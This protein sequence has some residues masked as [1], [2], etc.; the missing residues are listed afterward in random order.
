[1]SMYVQLSLSLPVV[2][3]PGTVMYMKQAHYHHASA[4]THPGSVILVLCSAD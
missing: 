3:Y 2:D 1:M 4:Q